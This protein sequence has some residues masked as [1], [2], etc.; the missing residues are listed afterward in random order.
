MYRP[1]RI[2]PWP[3]VD[4]NN[5]VHGVTGAALAGGALLWPILECYVNADTVNAATRS[6]TIAQI[7]NACALTTGEALGIGCTILGNALSVVESH[8]T[9]SGMFTAFFDAVGISIIPFVGR[10]PDSAGFRTLDE[11]VLL[12]PIMSR[13]T[14]LSGSPIECGVNMSG[15]IGDWLPGGAEVL[16]AIVGGFL[17]KNSSTGTVTMTDMMASISVHRYESDILSFEPNR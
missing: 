3:L 17:I 8:I 7:T 15:V 2:G 13:G 14:G 10:T 5:S 11:L 9:V 16:D 4:L 6:D 1:N 12:P